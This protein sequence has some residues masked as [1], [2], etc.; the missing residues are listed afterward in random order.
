[1]TCCRQLNL[2]MSDNFVI[3]TIL[4]KRVE[5]ETDIKLVESG[6]RKLENEFRD[7]RGITIGFDGQNG[8][9]SK[10]EQI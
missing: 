6:L 7:L 3:E 8:L 10:I 2:N 5:V 9:R 4:K 1:M